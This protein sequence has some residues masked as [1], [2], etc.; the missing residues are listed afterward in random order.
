MPATAHQQGLLP[1]L[2]RLQQGVS[3]DVS[4]VQVRIVHPINAPA[5]KTQN[6]CYSQCSPPFLSQQLPSLVIVQSTCYASVALWQCAFE[7]QG[8]V[9]TDQLAATLASRC[10]AVCRSHH[11]RG[12]YAIASSVGEALQRAL[13][14]SSSPPCQ[15]QQHRLVSPAVWTPPNPCCSWTSWTPS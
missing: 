1:L 7:H 15:Q 10:I 2:S 12:R 3:R 14:G 5:P 13:C 9:R 11:A 4:R 8:T 6:R